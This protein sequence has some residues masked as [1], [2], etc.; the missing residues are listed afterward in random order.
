VTDVVEGG[1]DVISSASL[2]GL[3]PGVSDVIRDIA[4]D[5]YGQIWVLS[6]L[7]TDT[8]LSAFTL[9]DINAGATLTQVDLDPDTANLH[10]QLSGIT[11][12]DGT[13]ATAG[14]GLA[15]NGNA[16][17]IFVAANGGTNQKDHVFIFENS[18]AIPEPATL[19][20]LAIGG[21]VMAGAAVRRRRQ[22]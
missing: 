19:G 4:N 17:E 6:S 7:G 2:N 16:S 10:V 13:T 5:L 3:V 9:S 20:L 15:V 18:A 12:T 1:G 22:H 14:V 11:L 8:Y 21:M